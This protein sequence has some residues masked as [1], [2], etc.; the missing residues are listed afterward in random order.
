MLRYAI[1]ELIP[2]QGETAALNRRSQLE[3]QLRRWSLCGVNFIQLREKALD[4]GEQCELARFTMEQ[5][6]R[7]PAGSP[8]PLL[9]LN[10]RADI[11]AAAR[12][13]GV[14][15]TSRAGELRPEQV[16]SVFRAAGLPRCFVSVSCH[17][18]AEVTA[19]RE[20]GADLVLFGPV[21]EKVIKGD[22][23]SGGTGLH[24]LGEACRQAIPVPVLALGGV[25]EEALSA[26]LN[27]GAAGVAAIRL[28]QR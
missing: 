22:P 16:R 26:C 17:Y 25:T 3:Q 6:S 20:H 24:R 28:F 10:G 18:L 11:A 1:T 13:D 5:L 15:L 8:R 14:H 27:A 2:G 12:A 23:V 7:L 19:A 9:L 4:A 21:F